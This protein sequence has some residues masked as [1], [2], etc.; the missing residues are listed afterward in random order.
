[1]KRA[2]L[3]KD[4]TNG[5]EGEGC[6]KNTGAGP[7]SEGFSEKEGVNMGQIGA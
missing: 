4:I 7:R 5:G 3:K 6:G 1:M 2:C